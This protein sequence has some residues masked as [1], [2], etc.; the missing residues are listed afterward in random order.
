VFSNENKMEFHFFYKEKRELLIQ[1]LSDLK[2]RK[3]IDYAFPQ[4][5]IS[6]LGYNLMHIGHMIM[7]LAATRTP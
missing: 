3:T 2:L 7:H 1:Q 4:T 6:T 5:Q